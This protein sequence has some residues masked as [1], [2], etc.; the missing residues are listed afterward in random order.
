MLM[1]F[2]VASPLVPAQMA[3]SSWKLF[4]QF[5]NASVKKIFPLIL[6]ESKTYTQ[7]ME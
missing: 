3:T 5:I 2:R 6:D 7:V 1:L 4:A